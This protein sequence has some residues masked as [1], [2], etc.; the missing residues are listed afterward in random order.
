MKKSILLLTSSVLIAVCGIVYLADQTVNEQV[1][2]NYQQADLKLSKE[3]TQNWNDAAEL[4]HSLYADINTGKIDR[5][6]LRLAKQ[7]VLQI[8]M[9]K[10]G[11]FTF[12]DEG[13]DNVGGRTRGIAIDPSDD[14]LIYAGSVSG[15]LFKSINAGSSWDRVQAFDDAVNAA[16][17][18]NGSISI[19]SIAITGNGNVYV[20]TGGSAYEG[21]LSGEGSG[22]QD[23]D[24]IWYSDNNGVTF[25]QLSGTNAVDVC[26]V[27]ADVTQTD[28]IYY[29][30]ISQGLKKV[31]NLGTPTAVT[32]V[33]T[34]TSID[35]K[36][37]NDGQVIIV[38]VAQGAQRTFVSQ[39]GGNNW[40]DLHSNNQLPGSG[41]SR[42]EYGISHEKDASGNYSIY[43][44]FANSASKLGGVFRSTD[45]GVNWCRIAPASTPGF[46]PLTSRSGQGYY[47]LVISAVPGSNA[48]ILGGIDLWKWEETPGGSCDNGEW[49]VIS[50]WALNPSN[51][52]YIHADNHRITWNSQGRMYVGN[53]GGVQMS[54][55]PQLGFF[56]VVNKGYNITQFYAIAYGGDGAVMGGTQD[57]GTQYNDHSGIG[58]LE[59][60]EVR[61]GDGFECE[62]SY[63]SS[64]A[65]IA[66][67]YN[68]DISRSDDRGLNWQ[69]QA[70]PC[71][72]TVGLDCGPFY[73][74]IRL[75]EDGM[76]MNT[77]DSIEFVPQ[78]E[79]GDQLMAMGEV[80][81]YYSQ[82]FSI[83]MEYTLTQDL[84]VTWESVTP[85]TDSIL[86]NFD[87]IFAGQTFYYNPIPQDTIMLPDYKQSLFATQG[88]ATI[89]ITRDMMR[90]GVTPEWWSLYPL[91]SFMNSSARSYDFSKDGNWLWI[92]SSNGELVRVSGLDSAYSAQAADYGNRPRDTDTLILVSN[93]DT[94]TGTALDNINFDNDSHLYTNLDGSK[95]Q[96]QLHVH[97][98]TS[99]ST[100]SSVITDISVDPADP[101]NVCVT[102]GG[103]SGSQVW[104]STNAT[105]S[106]PSFSAIDGN[107]PNMPVF[108]C[109]IEKDPTTD[110]IILGTEYGVF[111]TDN[112]SAGSVNWTAHNEEIGPIPVFDVRQQWRDWEDGIDSINRFQVVNNPGAIYL[113]THGR[114]IWRSDDVLHTNEIKPIEANNELAIDHLNIFPNPV[115]E[116]GKVYFE[117]SKRTDV[118]FKIYDLQGKLMK[119]IT[120]KN[121][122]K[123]SHTMNFDC[124]DFPIGT[125][126]ATVESLDVN[127]V[128][129]FVKY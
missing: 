91:G 16:A 23:G 43:A 6:Q 82:S 3:K 87:T 101:N 27:V 58:P 32:G 126:F 104:Y 60:K 92:G 117:L 68:G 64:D 11:A 118:T 105:S 50:N 25:Q 30:G 108:G 5:D 19:S 123:G 36:V 88:D 7:E 40:T 129:K 70:A 95:V 113:G 107:L 127:K 48:C 77:Q 49:Q 94:V 55:G 85:L 76:D 24:G 47:D 93:G 56:S 122:S 10:S 79:D 13:P 98:V 99:P 90:F 73:N 21:G 119:N 15:G 71:S 62:I 121:M 124:T 37:S 65:I 39:D 41:M 33:T 28:L 22:T 109:V 74:A 63:L 106:S 102:R 75:F 46:E 84:T 12:V 69:D 29:V 78:L 115:T 59:F 61:G 8:M 4:Y 42:V 96:Y 110:Y 67:V 17:S 80:A 128:A 20:A 111:S 38:G 116:E 97:R 26:K 100:F 44:V 72:G 52:Q 112:P 81:T 31:E 1:K 125:Y 120:W 114:G 9:Q 53:D 35:V 2:R 34:A 14:N 57:N 18:G 66:T 54:F 83:P 51:P 86:P 89:Y 103:T 45:N